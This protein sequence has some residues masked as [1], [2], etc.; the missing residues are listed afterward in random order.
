MCQLEQHVNGLA[1]STTGGLTNIKVLEQNM[2]ERLGDAP[3]ESA[4]HGF[5]NSLGRALQDLIKKELN[6]EWGFCLMMFPLGEGPGRCNYI[7]NA[8][9]EDVVILLKEQLARFEGMPEAQG[10]G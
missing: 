8:R 1:L 6:G 4:V 3:I 9:R 7:S 10:K 5:M 2:N